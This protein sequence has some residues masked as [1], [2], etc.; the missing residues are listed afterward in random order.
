MSE[1]PVFTA[2]YLLYFLLAL[3]LFWKLR[4][5]TAVFSLVLTGW[6]LLP[7]GNYPVL[8]LGENFPFWIIGLALPSD[9]SWGKAGVIGVIVVGGAC[10]FDW[11]RVR[12]WRFTVWDLPIAGW[13]LWSIVRAVLP[14]SDLQT[15]TFDS[16]YLL[17]T[18]GSM[19]WMGR[20][21]LQT[22]EERQLFL[23]SVVLA[24]LL[25]VPLALYEGIAGPDFYQWVYG[26]THPFRFVGDE[27]YLGYRPILF[28]EDG[29]QYGLWMTAGALCAVWLV[30]S[31]L[32]PL[33]FASAKWHYS[34][35]IGV[36][37]VLVFMA[38]VAQSVGA[39]L[40]G[41]MVMGVLQLSRWFR[42]AVMVVS[43][44]ALLAAVGAVYL[45]G[46]VP[47]YQIGKETAIGRKAV[48]VF[49]SVGRGSFA[50]RISQDQKLL[51][52]AKDKALIGQ[53]R[54]DW[55]REKGTR[56]WGMPVLVLGQWGII[57]LML[58]FS[59]WLIGSLRASLTTQVAEPYQIK[60][61]PWFL[62]LLGMFAALDGL[63]NS[64]IFFPALMLSGAL[65]NKTFVK[66]KVS[67]G[68]N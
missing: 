31:R 3:L 36:A 60:Q 52:V 38:L 5:A 62:A 49:R 41:L 42:P 63:M 48:D 15:G 17:A 21:Y 37:A 9:V 66:S 64:F 56:P 58:C 2:A 39:I 57:G 35:S 13:C 12:Q 47:I 34:W 55:W 1:F 45:S 51:R 11:K 23:Q 50:W 68:R 14:G 43:V 61:M 19:W 67:T 44:A 32:R 59:A 4:P 29:N 33:P 53:G 46:A 54:W 7:V 26:Q 8:P 6:W 16:L 24:S 28:F 18:W 22:V 10:L 27:R 40:L 65:V 25:A 30:R 20:L